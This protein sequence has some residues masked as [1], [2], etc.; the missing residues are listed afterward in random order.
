MECQQGFNHDAMYWY[1]QDPGKGLRQIYYSIAEKDI[2][3]GELSEG[4]SVSR[5]KKPFFPLTVTSAQK[6]Q[7]AV[8]LCASSI[9]Q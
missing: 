6:N 8:Y 4:Y 2:Q 5:E 1:R 3:K 7:M 9:T